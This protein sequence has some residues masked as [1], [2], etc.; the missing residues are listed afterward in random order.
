METLSKS[1][2][3]RIAKDRYRFMLT[4][5]KYLKWFSYRHGEVTVKPS[6]ASDEHLTVTQTATGIVTTVK[7]AKSWSNF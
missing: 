3:R 4:Q 5:G 6:D 1:D 7:I 2:A